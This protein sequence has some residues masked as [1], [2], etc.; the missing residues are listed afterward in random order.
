MTGKGNQQPSPCQ[1]L[2]AGVMGSQAHPL[3]QFLAAG[4]TGSQAHPL[5][6]FPAAEVKGLQAHPLCP[7]LKHL[8][9]IWA[10]PCPEPSMHAH[11]I[12]IPGLHIRSVSF[13]KNIFT[14][15]TRRL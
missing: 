7:E 13:Y 10:T 15:P 8:V 11:A 2:A 4:V 12:V 6:Q 5:C 9:N 1:F 3:C 14:F